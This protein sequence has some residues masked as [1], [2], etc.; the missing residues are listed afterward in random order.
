MRDWLGIPCG[1]VVH[2]HP[3]FLGAFR[4]HLKTTSTHVYRLL[5]FVPPCSFSLFIETCVCVLML[6]CC[7][8][9]FPFHS[10]KLLRLAAYTGVTL[11][12][13][14]QLVCH[15]NAEKMAWDG[16]GNDEGDGLV[17]WC[18]LTA[19]ALVLP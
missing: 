15:E 11:L 3:S 1:L 12:M 10:Q 16:I 6:L 8:L 4:P 13:A 17:D 9:L 2:L 5:C 18:R 14:W 19:D 7:A